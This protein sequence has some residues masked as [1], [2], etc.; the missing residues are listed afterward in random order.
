MEP[1]SLSEKYKLP[2]EIQPGQTIKAITVMD[3]GKTSLMLEK[4]LW[5]PKDKWKIV[6]VSSENTVSGETAEKAIDDDPGTI[7]HSQWQGGLAH[8]PHEIQI[9]LGE[10][11]AIKGIA[12]LP[13]QSGELNGTAGQCAVYTSIDGQT[14]RTAVKNGIFEDIIRNRAE[15]KVYFDSVYR[16]RYLRFLIISEINGK[17]FG[18]IAELGVIPE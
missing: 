15:Q 10:E 4:S 13:R 8:P 2:I 3:S 5:Y 17:H 9:D 7:W 6:H 12:Y 11:I 18:S 16:A 14:W 1:S